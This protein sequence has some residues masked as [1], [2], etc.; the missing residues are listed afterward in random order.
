M[1]Q[2]HLSD[3]QFA[4]MIA[5]QYQTGIKMRTSDDLKFVGLTQFREKLDV[6]MGS[7]EAEFMLNVEKV[8]KKWSE[9][10]GFWTDAADS[11][12]NHHRHKGG[13]AEINVFWFE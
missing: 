3:E 1:A 4:K 11:Y 13:S 8:T 12:H 7:S 5:S 6:Y 2:V 9:K 10:T